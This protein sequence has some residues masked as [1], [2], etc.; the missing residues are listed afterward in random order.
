MIATKDL[1]AWSPDAG[2]ISE[3]KDQ[4]SR[5]IGSYRSNPH[6]IS[7]HANLEELNPSW[8]VREPDAAGARSERC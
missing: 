2:L 3:I 1:K 8:R 5:A 6:L 7:E 4:F